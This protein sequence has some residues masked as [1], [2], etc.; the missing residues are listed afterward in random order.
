MLELHAFEV[1]AFI[2][3]ENFGL[4]DFALG[5]QSCN[6]I[7]GKKEFAFFGLHYGVFIIRMKC[8]SAIVRDGPRS[9]SPDHRRYIVA[10][11][12]G[13]VFAAADYREFH[14]DGRA[15]MVFVFDFGFGERRGIE[16]AP[17]D[18]LASTVHVALFHKVEERVGDSGFVVEAHREIRI[19]PAAKNSQTFEIFLMLFDVAVGEGPAQLA[20]FRRSNFTFAAKFFFDLCFD[21]KTVAIPPGNIRGIVAGHALGLDDQI[22]QNFIQAGAQVDGACGIGRAIVQNKQRLSGAGMQNFL[23]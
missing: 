6:A 22:F 8:E 23:I 16:K 4:L 13:F 12:G 15:D 17:I 1:A 20:E 21:G 10:N 11:F 5:L 18:W 3:P 7:R 2:G 9:G 19:V 14:P